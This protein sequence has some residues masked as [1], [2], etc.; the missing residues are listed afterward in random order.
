MP[1][2]DLID[3]VL[4]EGVHDCTI[5]EI[6]AVF[7]RFQRSGRRIEL[8]A[9]LRAYLIEAKRVGVVSVYVDGSYITAKD[10]PEDIDLIVILPAAWDFTRELKPFEYNTV[11]KSGIKRIKLPFDLFVY[12]EGSDEIARMV[13]FFSQTNRVKYP[14]FTARTQ[15]GL[16][17]VTL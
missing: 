12:A 9:K 6:A 10:E 11:T 14:E 15:K 8:T 7:G 13:A 17:R 4:P 2:P 16:L 3:N 5:D 1:I